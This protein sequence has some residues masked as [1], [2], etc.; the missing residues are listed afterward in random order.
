MLPCTFP[1]IPGGLTAA[2]T[3]AE[4][5]LLLNQQ[6]MKHGIPF[7]FLPGGTGILETNDEQNYE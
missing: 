3:V 7:S 6:Q 2:G 4:F 1:E 5:P